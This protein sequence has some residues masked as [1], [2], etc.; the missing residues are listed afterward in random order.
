[1][2]IQMYKEIFNRI[3]NILQKKYASLNKD[4]DKE[5]SESKHVKNRYKRLSDREIFWTMVTKRFL[6]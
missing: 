2:Q 1:M 5:F 6:S 3:E 4:F